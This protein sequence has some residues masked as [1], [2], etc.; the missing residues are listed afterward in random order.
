M[1]TCEI[2]LIESNEYKLFR[3]THTTQQPKFFWSIFKVLE[4]PSKWHIH[5]Q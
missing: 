1:E 5:V 4:M 2:I 3:T